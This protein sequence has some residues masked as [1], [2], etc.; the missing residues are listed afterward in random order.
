MLPSIL[1]GHFPTFFLVI[2]TYLLIYKDKAFNTKV[3]VEF[4][5]AL[6]VSG[7]LLV[8][9]AIC[10]AG[11]FGVAESIIVMD[12]VEMLF[13]PVLLAILLAIVLRNN[14]GRVFRWAILPA[15]INLVLTVLSVWTGWLFYIEDGKWEGGPLYMFP[16]TLFLAYL[17]AI[18]VL[19]IRNTNANETLEH[20]IVFI[21]A[22]TVAISANI[23]FSFDC[24]NFMDDIM[25]ICICLYYF[26][27]V[28]QVYKRDALTGLMNRH[29]L[30][31]DMEELVKK[32]YLITIIDIDNFKMINDKYGHEKGDAVIKQ[33]VDTMRKYIP[34]KCRLYRFGG[35]EFAVIS[36]GLNEEQLNAIFNKVNE[37][38]EK[39]NQRIS[40]G[41]HEH[42]PNEN[43]WDALNTA[44]AV[45]YE[46]K[47]Q[48]KSEDIWD[49]MT[50]L[51]NL[52]GFLDELQLFNKQATA[53]GKDIG[54]VSFDIEHLGS[55]NKAYGYAEGNMLIGVL[56]NV[57]KSSL[58]YREFAGHL[59]SD[60]FVV[61]F[62]L[63]KTEEGHSGDL[64]EKVIAG[65]HHAPALDN[66]EYTVEINAAFQ[67]VAVNK[68][69]SL[70]DNVNEV[71]YQKRN[72]KDNRRKSSFG[73]DEVQVDKDEEALALDIIENNKL[74][75]ALQPIVSAKDGSIVAYEALMRSDTEPMVS[76]LAILRHAKNHD[77]YYEIEKYTFFNI[78]E[79]ISQNG[80]I[81]EN[82]RVFMNSIPGSILTDE[83]HKAFTDKYGSLME[84]VVV[85]ITE[86]S[87]LTDSDL[88]VIKARQ[89]KYGF[90]I[91]IDDYGSGNANTYSLLKIQPQIIKLDRLLISD[92]DTNSKK[93]YFVNSIITF[94]KENGMQVLAEGVETEAELKMVIRLQVDY[95]QGY[96]TAKPSFTALDEIDEK[97]KHSIVNENIRGV[98]ESKRKI[99]VASNC[100]ELSLVQ[101]A[102]EEYTGITISTPDIKLVGSTDYVA[103]MN[104]KIMDGLR[105]RMTL[106]DVRLNAIDD[107]PCIELGEGAE[108]TIMLEGNCTI[109]QKGIYVPEGSSLIVK[110]AGTLVVSTKG[111]DC[112]GIGCKSDEAIGNITFNQ[113]GKIEIHVD[114]EQCAA[115]GGGIYKNGRGISFLSGAFDINVASVN[116]VGIGCFKGDVPISIN[117]CEVMMELRLNIGSGIGSVDGLQNIELKNYKLIVTG[118]G[119][120]LSGIGTNNAS[121]GSIS[122]DSGSVDITMSGQEICMIGSTAGNVTVNS[123][124]VRFHM[125]GEGDQVMAMGSMDKTGSL[126]FKESYLD[127]VI[128]SA[129]PLAFGAE[130]SNVQI[131]GPAPALHVNE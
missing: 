7:V 58:E 106:K 128:N 39:V 71:L 38:L 114:G 131:L 119:S 36:R 93:Q 76:P 113:S 47:R 109:D 20:V 61:A 100:S 101:V 104:I 121:G 89:V 21:M 63:D 74:R 32:S 92:I 70:E 45:M 31:Y 94:A 91:A 95:I 17:I 62:L 117:D 22:L 88:A 11:V 99:Y 8:S 9:N 111:H 85:E 123:Q 41:S 12:F 51:Y 68:D 27:L 97:V 110:G 50:G 75:Y 35:D 3:R 60:E 26:Y 24:R 73:G 96:Y 44:D 37:A 52:R 57:I 98:I 84:K 43:V 55:I 80:S 34:K 129:R 120:K 28:M 103:D 86:Q 53:E 130:E 40:Y 127:V 78:M 102:L 1:Q 107:L 79:M 112:Y 81:I 105:C 69:K 6:I 25:A 42:A 65:V 125:K 4:Y 33:V 124:H 87:E 66:K 30:V 23:E 48:L 64:I 56:A 16:L 126:Q 18:V 108:L 13:R 83:D 5:T 72:A 29:N 118:S 115:I 2:M 77:K 14:R 116:A 19:S 49:D 10:E 59:G 122:M 90:G 54:L 15:A 67:R 46:N 82:K